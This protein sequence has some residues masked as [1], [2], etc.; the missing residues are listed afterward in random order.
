M[1]DE[2]QGARDSGEQPAA[3]ARQH[4]ARER[5]ILCSDP[6]VAQSPEHTEDGCDFDVRPALIRLRSSEPDRLLR[7]CRMLAGHLL[8]EDC[9]EGQHDAGGKR[10]PPEHGCAW[11]K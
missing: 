7:L 2:P 8:G 1:E 5:F 10:Q 6:A 11:R 3:I 4:V 9:D